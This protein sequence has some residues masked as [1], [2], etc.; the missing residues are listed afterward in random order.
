M[1][2]GG[3]ATLCDNLW[4]GGTWKI[5]L[6]TFFSSRFENTATTRVEFGTV[7]LYQAI[8]PPSVFGLFMRALCVKTK[9]TNKSCVSYW[10]PGASCCKVRAPTTTL[11][12]NPFSWTTFMSEQEYFSNSHRRQAH[13]LF[14]VLLLPLIIPLILIFKRL[15]AIDWHFIK[16]WKRKT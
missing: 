8:C 16:T 12:S 6:F 15:A 13:Q 3:A 2:W 1:C 9:Q 5:C 7:L 14:F 4:I 11:S 10:L